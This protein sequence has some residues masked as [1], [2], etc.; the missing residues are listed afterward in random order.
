MCWTYDLLW[1]REE[2]G[3]DKGSDDLLQIA[4]LWTE[5]LADLQPRYQLWVQRFEALA[6]KQMTWLGNGEFQLDKLSS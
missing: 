3:E 2:N 1:E 6:G 5:V 4:K